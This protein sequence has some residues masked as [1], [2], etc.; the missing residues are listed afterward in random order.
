MIKNCNNE[1][2]HVDNKLINDLS[3][4]VKRNLSETASEIENYLHKVE[5][6]NLRISIKAGIKMQNLS[7]F[8]Y[9]ELDKY[10]RELTH[11]TNNHITRLIIGTENE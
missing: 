7:L 10:L 6:E 5:E 8:L 11:T 9:K 1:L 4:L 2:S 3:G